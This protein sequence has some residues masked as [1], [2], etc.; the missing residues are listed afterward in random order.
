MGLPVLKVAMCQMLV[1]PGLPERNLG[2]A[3]RMICD[4]AAAGCE[5]AVLPECLDLGWTFPGAPG[6]AEPIPGRFSA[7]LCEA[8]RGA[9]IHVVAGLTE[10]AGVRLHNAAILVSPEGR[11]LLLHRKINLLPGVEEIYSRGDRLVVVR[12]AGATIGVNICEDNFPES[13]ELGRSLALMGADILLSP[14]AWAVDADHDNRREPY[15][16]LWRGAYGTLARECGLPVVGV[17]N[18]GRIEG[19]PWRGRKCIGCSLA[20]GAGGASLAEGPYGEA[21]EALMPVGVAPKSRP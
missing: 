17:S 5:I 14:C 21:A 18:V 16:D 13:L 1:E 20:V 12:A 10:R 9:G 6:M 11:I 2:R 4:A 8:A 3:R 7:D 19:G 15:G